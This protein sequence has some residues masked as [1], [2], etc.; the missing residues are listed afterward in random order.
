[1]AKFFFSFIHFGRAGDVYD[2]CIILTEFPCVLPPDYEFT[3]ETNAVLHNATLEYES[4]NVVHTTFTN[5]GFGM[6][7]LGLSTPNFS[8]EKRADV[9]DRIQCEGNE[10]AK[11]G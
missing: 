8:T 2:R 3:L 5:D 1:M 11:D 4:A 9:C 6:S 10:A 7:F